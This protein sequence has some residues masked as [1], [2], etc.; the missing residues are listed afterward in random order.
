MNDIIKKNLEELFDRHP[1]LTDQREQIEQAIEMLKECY[2]NGGRVLVC[3]NGG[4]ASDAMHI[5]GE[6]MKTFRLPRKLD[7]K[8]CQK[9]KNVSADADYLCA[10]LQG[11]LPAVSLVNEASLLTAF[12]NDSAP[13]LIFAQQVYGYGTPKDILWIISTSG[14]SKN[15]VL[16]AEIAKVKEMQ[17]ISLTGRGGGR[18][19]DKSDVTIAVNEAE[20][21]LVQELHE[22]VYHAICMTLEELF[23]S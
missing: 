21:Y 13:D 12:I 9:I 22:P 10:N 5:V 6:L 19:K 2:Q 11:A 7:E 23:F 4:S 1:V 14:N 18:L 17:V 8:E 15:V 20:T 16:A 3:G